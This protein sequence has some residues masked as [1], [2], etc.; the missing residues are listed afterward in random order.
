M[1]PCIGNIMSVSCLQRL[2]GGC[3]A[4]LI[5]ALLLTGCHQPKVAPATDHRQG[6]RG[7]VW[8]K[9][10][11]DASDMTFAL[12]PPDL[13]PRPLPEARVYLMRPGDT[14]ASTDIIATTLTDSL[15][16]Y[17]L[18]AA[19]GKYRVAVVVETVPTVGR[20]IPSADSSEPGFLENALRVVE[21]R[22]GRFSELDFEIGELVPQ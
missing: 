19:A 5:L 11:Y 4:G 22:A 8:L 13:T 14:F 10:D 7:V 20:Y 18:R 15:G 6:V 9:P 21:I 12:N 16:H 17:V 3:A 2:A 1:S